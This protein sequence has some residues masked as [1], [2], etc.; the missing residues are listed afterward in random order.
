MGFWGR[1]F[2]YESDKSADDAAR[3]KP[4]RNRF[5]RGWESD[6]EDKQQATTGEFLDELGRALD[7]AEATIVPR[8]TD[9]DSDLRGTLQ[10]F[11]LKVRVEWD[12]DVRDVV[13]K[14][15]DTGLEFID[16]EYDPALPAKAPEVDPF[17]PS[18]KQVILGPGVYVEGS[19][20]DREAALFRTLPGDLQ[21]RIIHMMRDYNVLYFRSR[22]DE[23]DITLRESD[24]AEWNGD[25]VI[26]LKS[27]LAIAA[28]MHL[29]RGARP[30]S[31]IQ[32]V[33]KGRPLAEVLA[34]KIAARIPG[35]KIVTREQEHRIDIRWSEQDVPVRLALDWEFDDLEIQVSA[36]GVAGEFS[37]EYDSDVTIDEPTSGDPW[38]APHHHPF[39]AK[40]TFVTGREAKARAEAAIVQSID[41]ELLARLIET[42]ERHEMWLTLE[43]E[44]LHTVFDDMSHVGDEGA[45]AIRV[46]SLLAQVAKGLPRGAVTSDVTAVRCTYCGGLWFP[47]PTRVNCSHCGAKA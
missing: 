3:P 44:L 14:C 12:G 38:D 8:P 45:E 39:L 17:E 25:P 35:A 32:G 24:L 15:A 28:E 20:A 41:G 18:E 37:I 22:D 36:T 46:A 30:P 40:N 33:A 7:L 27:I 6:S 42:C 47:G 4:A 43:E 9:R 2:G 34:P 26:R 16:L 29:E 21:A 11:P 13:F 10:G 23:F 5:A 1:F 31:A 19:S